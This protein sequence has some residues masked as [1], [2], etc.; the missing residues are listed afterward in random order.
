MSL[1]GY[2]NDKT[3]KNAVQRAYQAGVVMVA[4]AGNDQR[5]LLYPAALPEVIAV[6]AVDYNYPNPPKKSYYSNFGPEMD[7]VTPGG[8]TR[9]D[10][11]GDGYVDG[12][13]ST[14]INKSREL[15]YEFLQG[16]S[17][18]CP[19][20]A[21]VAALMV[22]NGIPP[23]EVKEVMTRTA[24]DL[25]DPGFD[26]Y[27]GHGHVNAYW[28]V[29]DVKEIKILVGT[30]NGNRIDAVKES[31]VDLKSKTF[32]LKDIPAGEYQVFAWIDVQNTGTIDPGDHLY[33]S[34]KMTF[35]DGQRLQVNVDL[36]EVK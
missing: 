35:S 23:R 20:G 27:F 11:D 14:N 15:V 6:G 10:S 5:G 9:V 18:A 3:M 16:T 19:H 2:E 33:E 25:G 22:A 34:E 1:G 32:E 24:S 7:V 31:K 36:K 26:H 12:I 21:G 13:M 8:D 4:A 28:A 17:M 29:C 30:R